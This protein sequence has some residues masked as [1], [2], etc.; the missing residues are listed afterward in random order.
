[1]IFFTDS[2]EDETEKS[3]LSHG[4]N[5][6]SLDGNAIRQVIDNVHETQVVTGK[7]TSDKI[8]S[9]ENEEIHS[10]H[11]DGTTEK[12]LERKVRLLYL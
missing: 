11:S 2:A 10:L 5:K 6:Q 7:G 3:T 1:M 4:S 9:R 12:S 8:K